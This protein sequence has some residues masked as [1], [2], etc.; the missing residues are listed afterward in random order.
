MNKLFLSLFLLIIFINE[1]QSQDYVPFPEDS[2][3]WT[4]AYEFIGEGFNLWFNELASIDGDTI[5]EG[6]EYQ[7]LYYHFDAD[8][9]IGES[10]LYA[11][12]I[13]ENEFRQ[14]FFKPSYYCTLNGE[15]ELRR[16]GLFPS[17]NEE[18][19]IYDFQDLNVGDSLDYSNDLVFPFE[20]VSYIVAD[21]DSILIGD[22]YR[23]RY[24][25]EDLYSMHY[26]TSYFI[27]GIGSS[28]GL[29]APFRPQSEFAGHARLILSCF[30]DDE[31]SFVSNLHEDNL[32]CKIGLSIE[33]YGIENLKVFPNPTENSQLN[34]VSSSEIERIE[35]Y[36]LQGELILSRRINSKNFNLS[37]LN[38]S[39]GLYLL[40]VV[41][42]DVI[43]TNKIEIN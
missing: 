40:Q 10:D 27:E 3:S 15:S 4:H 14:I 22:V 31:I 11:G 9:S 35:L 23:K 2:S 37:T 17:S 38:I 28:L 5:I 25:M 6:V 33:E 12:G 43:I 36:S 34:M 24:V 18:Y 29:L 1:A 26:S 16:L 39:S 42:N 8:I 20:G 41:I 32:N 7:K 13:R 19:L 21:I 30:Q